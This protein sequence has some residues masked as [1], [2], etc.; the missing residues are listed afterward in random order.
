[1]K[2]IT[3]DIGDIVVPQ[4]SAILET[5]LGSCVSVCL[6]D[7]KL[8]IGGMNHFMMPKANGNIK[9]PGHSGA[10]SIKEL[11]AKFLKIGSNAQYITARMFGGNSVIKHFNQEHWFV[12]IGKENV[13]VAKEVLRKYNIPIVD[14]LILQDS[15]IKIAFFT[16]TGEA[17]VKYLGWCA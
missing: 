7:S 6:W 16:E 2:K 3:L 14:E 15:G 11:I 13:M 10:E 8:H 9:H 1:M 4:E 17:S 5:I 12:N